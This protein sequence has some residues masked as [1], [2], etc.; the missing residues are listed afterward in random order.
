MAR[1][2]MEDHEKRTH[3]HNV[4]LTAAELGH[5]QSQATLAGLEVTEYIRLKA[6]GTVVKSKGSATRSDPALITKINTMALQLRKAG[7]TANKMAVAVHSD[8]SFPIR[9]QQV[10]DGLD[11]ARANAEA[12]LSELV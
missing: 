2:K 3:R 5:I 6:M 1:P 7:V 4:R 12:V 8:Q 11:A 10:A 9:W